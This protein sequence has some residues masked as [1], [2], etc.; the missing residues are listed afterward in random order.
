[1]SSGGSWRSASIETIASPRAAS[2]PALSAAWCPKFLEMR[3]RRRQ[4]EHLVPGAV[5]RAVVD[6]HDLVVAE[7]RERSAQATHEHGQDLLLVEDG[8][9]DREHLRSVN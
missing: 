3:R 8:G 4:Q 1:M 9:D 6:E 7:V 2:R 5:G